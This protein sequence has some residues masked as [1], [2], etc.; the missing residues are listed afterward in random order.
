[1]S[2]DNIDRYIDEILQEAKTSSQRKITRAEKISRAIGNLSVQKAKENN[3]SLYT[4]YKKYKD[5]YKN[6]KQ[7]IIKKYAPKV[8]SQAKK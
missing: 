1:M 5:L 6:Y 7:K 8:R 3:D 4:K 2:Y